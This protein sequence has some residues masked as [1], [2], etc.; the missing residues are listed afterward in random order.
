MRQRMEAMVVFDNLAEISLLFE[1]GENTIKVKN[2]VGRLR[3]V[4]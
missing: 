2:D 3:S 4:E 1:E